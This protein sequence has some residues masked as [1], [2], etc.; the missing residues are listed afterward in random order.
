MIES[1]RELLR[2]A[3]DSLESEQ[4]D[5]AAEYIEQAMVLLDDADYAD[6]FGG[7]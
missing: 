5:T 3:M 2:A 7:Y 6:N 4:P 1:I